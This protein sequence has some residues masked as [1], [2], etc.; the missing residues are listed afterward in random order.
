M[1]RGNAPGFPP[2]ERILAT[3]TAM[4]LDP[5]QK[6]LFVRGSCP[7]IRR[8]VSPRHRFHCPIRHGC[9]V[10]GAESYRVAV[11]REVCRSLPPVPVGIISQA[12]ESGLLDPPVTV[13]LV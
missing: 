11:L 1:G 5:A 4:L 12:E 2:C 9:D 7:D 10:Y 8:D 6:L 3:C 13:S